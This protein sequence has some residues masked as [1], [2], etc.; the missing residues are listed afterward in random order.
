MFLMNLSYRQGPVVSLFR[1]AD[2]ML[3]SGFYHFGLQH[4]IRLRVPVVPGEEVGRHQLT[5]QGNITTSQ[6]KVTSQTQ[7][8]R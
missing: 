7:S 5:V 3:Y 4:G 2:E 8:A 1:I 6:C